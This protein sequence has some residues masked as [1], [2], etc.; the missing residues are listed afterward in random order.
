MNAYLCTTIRQVLV[1]YAF[2][3]DKADVNISII[4]SYLILTGFQS[5]AFYILFYILIA[6]GDRVRLLFVYL[7]FLRHSQP[8]T[9]VNDSIYPSIIS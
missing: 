9:R 6:A 4:K 5:S 7:A 1:F 3:I 8:W 2:F